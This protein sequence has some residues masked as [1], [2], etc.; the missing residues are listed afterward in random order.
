MQKFMRRYWAYPF[1]VVCCLTGIL[2]AFS[3]NDSTY[4]RETACSNVESINQQIQSLKELRDYYS[5]KSVRLHARYD[6]VLGQ[7]NKHEAENLLKQADDCDKIV[8]NLNMKIDE[9]RKQ[10]D[11]DRRSCP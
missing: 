6:R 7:G 3:R 2:T 9:L 5:A 4:G 11:R 1:F 10:R 8:E